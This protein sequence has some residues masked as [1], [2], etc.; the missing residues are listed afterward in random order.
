MQ[1]NATL[2]KVVRNPVED[3]LPPGCK[4]I[5]TVRWTRQGL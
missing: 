5:A 4:K 2:M 1:G 3:H